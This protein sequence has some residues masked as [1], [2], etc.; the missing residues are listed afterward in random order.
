MNT[1]GRPRRSSSSTRISV[2]IAAVE[3]D[4]QNSTTSSSDPPTARWMTRRASSRERRRTQAGRGRLGMR[5]R[6][7]RQHALPD[8]VLDERERTPRRGVVGVHE[9]AWAERAIQ[10]HV[11]AD[12]RPADPL[13][14]HGPLELGLLVVTHLPI[15]SRVRFTPTLRASVSTRR[16]SRATASIEWGNARRRGRTPTTSRR[17]AAG[18]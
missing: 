13:H 18:W 7:Q 6:V 9:S 10:D 1:T 12:H 17:R 8:V 5:V 11:V 16:S 4:P 14:G 2:S 3:P 15:P